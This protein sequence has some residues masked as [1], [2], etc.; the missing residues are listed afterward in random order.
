MSFRELVIRFSA[1]TLF[2]LV[3]LAS[4][5]HH[6]GASFDN[7][8]QISLVGTVHEF[9]WTNPH[10]WIQLDT[11]GA[12]GVEQWSIEMAAPAEVF[13]GGWRPSTLKA[14]Q[15]V[16]VIVNPARD[17]SKVGLFVSAVNASGK[18]IGKRL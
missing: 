11:I 10:C 16:R 14:G 5:A 13:R 17:G 2:L 18:P 12:A 4:S 6:S 7:K 9:Q 8:R 1:G 3:P 15:A